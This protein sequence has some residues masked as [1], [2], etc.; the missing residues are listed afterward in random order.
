M[1]ISAKY[2]EKMD[3]P[4]F[5]LNMLKVLF[6]PDTNITI[7]TVYSAFDNETNFFLNCNIENI[8]Y[9]IL[10]HK[11]LSKYGV[12]RNTI[13]NTI[14]FMWDLDQYTGDMGHSNAITL[15]TICEELLSL[16]VKN[17]Y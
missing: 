6:G 3:L 7:S 11:S 5:E 10:R 1:R 13:T 9:I 15:L 14:Q 17:I 12:D 8:I 16:G 4:D 2:L